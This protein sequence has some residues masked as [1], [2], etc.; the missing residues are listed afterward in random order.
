[1][2]IKVA[3]FDWVGRMRQNRLHWKR[4][5]A[6]CGK[7]KESWKRHGKAV[8]DEREEKETVKVGR[9]GSRETRLVSRLREGE[10]GGVFSRSKR[11]RVEPYIVSGTPNS[12]P[13]RK[14]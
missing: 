13:N 1:M 11:T 5:E 10:M 4:M 12:M 3:L 7:T 2:V 14:D 8:E 6:R 9:L